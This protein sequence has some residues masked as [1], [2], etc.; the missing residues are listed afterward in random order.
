[1]KKQLWYII[2]FLSLL[3][4][5]I[6]TSILVDRHREKNVNTF[7]F[8]ETVTAIN[9][10]DNFRADTI[11]MIIAHLIMEYDTVHIDVFD[12]PDLKTDEFEIAAFIQKTEKPHHYQVFLKKTSKN[13]VMKFLSHELIHMDQMERGDLITFIGNDKYNVFKGDTIR[14]SEVPY[15]VRPYEAEAFWSEGKVFKELIQHLYR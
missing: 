2:V 7:E 3:L 14:F 13:Y 10:T 15:R 11:V 9:H 5:V 4:G 1:M 12:A 6:V 8:P